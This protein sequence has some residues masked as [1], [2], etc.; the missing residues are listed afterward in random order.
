VPQAAIIQG[1]RGT[2]LFVIEDGNKAAL[3]PVRITHSAGTD[4]VVEGVRPGERVVV[5][6]KQNLRPGASVAERGPGGPGG[7]GAEGAGGNGTQGN[8]PGGGAGQGGGNGASG[9]GGA[10][11]GGGTG[12][13]A[14][15]AAAGGQEPG[16][17]LNVVASRVEAVR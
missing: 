10:A 7:R 2:T 8:Q 14:G 9:A 15:A 6:G 4:A 5:D 17:T 12:N 1:P 16:R 13:G 11:S 3:R